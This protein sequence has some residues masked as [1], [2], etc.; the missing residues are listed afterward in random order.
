MTSQ[1]IKDNQ[2]EDGG[3]TRHAEKG[4]SKLAMS[5][6][7]S[8][9][10][11]ML[12]PKY[13]AKQ[14]EAVKGTALVLV[15][16]LFFVGLTHGVALEMIDGF[17][18]GG[19]TWWVFCILIYVEALAAILCL[20]GLWLVDPGVV[21]RSR[22]TSFPIPIEMQQLIEEYLHDSKKDKQFSP[23]TEHYF[24]A[25]DGSGDTYCTRCLVWR[26]KEDGRHYHCNTCQRCVMQY[27]HHCSVFGRC[28]LRM[29]FM[30]S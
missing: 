30:I 27:D 9:L 17:A 13:R 11:S 20:H 4:I 12:Q 29:V 23:P 16:I 24:T 10:P 1:H 3:G 18:Y 25:D 15:L 22:K 5:I 21:K 8:G 6:E 2:I 28:V 19:T 14:R 26:R 7:M